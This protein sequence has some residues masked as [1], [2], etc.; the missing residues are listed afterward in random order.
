MNGRFAKRNGFADGE[1]AVVSA[2]DRKPG[3]VQIPGIYRME[4]IFEARP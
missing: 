2:I 1:R 4:K 3:Y